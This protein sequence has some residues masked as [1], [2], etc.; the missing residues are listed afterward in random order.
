MTTIYSKRQS[1]DDLRVHTYMYI[2]TSIIQQEEGDQYLVD[3]S[4]AKAQYIA[5]VL[6]STC[7]DQPNCLSHC[8]RIECFICAD[9][10]SHALDRIFSM[11][12]WADI[13]CS[14]PTRCCTCNSYLWGM[15][16]ARMMQLQMPSICPHPW[17]LVL[18]PPKAAQ[19]QAGMYTVGKTLTRVGKVDIP[20]K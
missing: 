9:T 15:M 16:R 20:H 1:I 2:H 19:D 5:E 8:V 13:P 7:P 14:P 11:V 17:R 6:L 12:I 4:D 18:I 3:S 10:W